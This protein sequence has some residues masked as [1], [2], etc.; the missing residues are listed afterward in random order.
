MKIDEQTRKS[1]SAEKSPISNRL[2]PI[3]HRLIDLI[4]FPKTKLVFKKNLTHRF[5]LCGGVRFFDEF[6]PEWVS[7][8]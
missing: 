7:G 3:F 6:L 4:D 8:R 5:F 1:M 2:A